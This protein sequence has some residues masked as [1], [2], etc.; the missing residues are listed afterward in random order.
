MAKG[1][2]YVELEVR[3][4]DNYR[5]HYISR[6]TPAVAKFGGAFVVR[7]GEVSVKNGPTDARRIVLVEFPTYE[8]ALAFYDSP[9]YAEAMRWRDQFAA[10]HRY[11]IL[12]G[13]D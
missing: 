8:Q 6:S 7:G 4:L 1:Y 11:V 12:R 3:D 5:T 2:I 13:A 10:V 9:D